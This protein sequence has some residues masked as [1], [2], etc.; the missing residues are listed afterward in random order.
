MNRIYERGMENGEEAQEGM[1]RK[2]EGRVGIVRRL[3]VC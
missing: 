2:T 1:K 3:P